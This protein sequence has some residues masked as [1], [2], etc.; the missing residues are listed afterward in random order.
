[1]HTPHHLEQ[2]AAR[3][4]EFNR[5]PGLL[6]Q[7]VLALDDYLKVQPLHHSVLPMGKTERPALARLLDPVR[8]ALALYGPEGAHHPS[9]CTQACV[10]VL[11]WQM[12]QGGTSLWAWD[13]SSWVHLIGKTKQAGLMARALG[14]RQP[15]VRLAQVREH[16]MC[17]AFLLGGVPIYSLVAPSQPVT[18]AARQLLGPGALATALA[19]IRT[20]LQRGGWTSSGSTP[21][22][23]AC[24]SQALLLARSPH[25]TDLTL[26]VLQRVY[27]QAI[28]LPYLRRA[29]L[30]L[31]KAL[32]GLGLLPE[33]L[34]AAPRQKPVLLG[35]QDSLPEA[36]QTLIQRWAAVESCNV[37][38]RNQV[39]V[40]AAKAARWSA[41][42]PGVPT[43]EQWT[44]PVALR[45]VAAVKTMQ[46]GQW[47]HPAIAGRYGPA[48]RDMKPASRAQL[49]N[50][51]RRFFAD[52][53]EW[54]WLPTLFSPQRLLATPRSIRDQCN[55]KPR[56]LEP[57]VWLK[58]RQASAALTAQDLAYSPLI[59]S[60]G[61]TTERLVHYPHEMVQALATT[62]LLT[63]LRSD[64]LGRLAVNCVRRLPETSGYA[65]WQLQ[66]E[67][68]GAC[69]LRVPRH[70]SGRAFEK[71]VPQVVGELLLAWQNLRP[72][73]PPQPDPKTGELT[74]F[75]FTRRG[76]T[77]G[78]TYL[79][80]RLI[81]LLCRKAGIPTHDAHGPITSHRARATL[82]TFL[83]NSGQMS[84]L[85]LMKWM[86]HRSM[87]TTLHYID[88]PDK[89]I[90]E[91]FLLANAYVVRQA[92]NAQQSQTGQVT[93]SSAPLS[94]ARLLLSVATLEQLLTVTSLSA[95]ERCSIQQS[96]QAVQHQL[97]LLPPDPE[98]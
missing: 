58:L 64:E 50:C 84:V 12:Q 95:A 79:N 71:P 43:P 61:R 37:G 60:D 4:L 16:L 92:E 2:W 56:V 97:T 78:R 46:M 48:E 38:V 23:A 66:D 57:H 86:G 55:I 63:G 20:E 45:F 35:V 51:L 14:P 24:L 90:I 62:W 6:A 29:C 42:Q 85:E 15:G 91:A 30:L 94:R 10:Q 41:C 18:V 34:V 33:A 7:E 40:A 89:K 49:L 8:H 81:P 52:C 31:S 93:P 72:A 39:L 70:K 80:H 1:M 54:R 22:L 73:T 74:D 19:T 44:G 68:P 11:G 27:E 98:A 76:A 53:Q 26:P 13:E 47:M 17:C 59:R 65:A 32:Q 83:Y 25:L 9:T 28:A 88:V 21:V 87:R 69:Y 77:I 75:L 82:V 67:V 96:L 3:L 36:W 5:E